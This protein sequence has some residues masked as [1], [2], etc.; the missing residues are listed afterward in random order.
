MTEGNKQQSFV[1]H[2]EDRSYSSNASIR[3]VRT[4]PRCNLF[5]V[6]KFIGPV[7]QSIIIKG[8]VSSISLTRTLFNIAQSIDDIDISAY[9]LQIR[10]A[11]ILLNGKFILNTLFYFTINCSKKTRKHFLS[12][13][14]YAAVLLEIEFLQ[15]QSNRDYPD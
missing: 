2:W 4:K 9:L 5:L 15:V 14:K 10:L 8:N 13:V 12:S 6:C 7:A 3:L 11:G 1:T